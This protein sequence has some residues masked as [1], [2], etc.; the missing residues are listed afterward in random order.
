MLQR[1]GFQPMLARTAKGLFALLIGFAGGYLFWRVGLPLPWMTGAMVFAAIAALVG[2][3]ASPPD[4][5]QP[6]M[7]AVVGTMLGAS[8]SMAFFVGLA[9]AAVP[10]A[11][12][13]ASAATGS[14]LAYLML[15]RV[16][17]LSPQTAYFSAMPGG[18]IEMV[19]MARE[20]GGDEMVVALVHASRIFFVVLCLPFILEWVTG[21]HAARGTGITV[22]LADVG[23]LD[24]V[25]FAGVVAA[26]FVL[27]KLVNLP[28]RF[29]FAPM[30]ASTFVHVMGWTDFKL[31]FELIAAAQVVIG[32][33]IGS[34]FGNVGNQ[35]ILH[36]L[37]LSVVVT[38]TLTSAAVAAAAV[39]HQISGIELASLILSYAPGGLGEMSLIALAMGFDVAFVVGNH[40]VRLILVITGAALIFDRLRLGSRS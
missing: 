5:L 35:R 29:M 37:G 19:L 21:M 28:A 20:R 23:A 6:P 8:F 12:L 11:G 15:R 31:P 9:S 13:L 38:A 39:V 22:T 24:V 17:G 18:V 2:L 25:W 30:I 26:G 32:A 34:R 7:L 16:A 40:L 33:G 36:T 27:S 3:P 14:F 10:L 1:Q 4:P